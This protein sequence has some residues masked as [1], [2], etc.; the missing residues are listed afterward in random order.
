MRVPRMV[1]GPQSL[2]AIRFSLFYWSPGVRQRWCVAHPCLVWENPP[3]WWALNDQL[4]IAGAGQRV[5]LT[6]DSILR[7]ASV[8][9]LTR[10]S[11]SP[12]AVMCANGY[13]HF[14]NSTDMD[15]LRPTSSPRLRCRCAHHAYCLTSSGV[16]PAG[17]S[18]AARLH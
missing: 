14:S 13:I 17:S 10:T 18:D 8:A 11:I 4:V 1:C 2:A 7:F 6:L 15:Q 5:H 16:G 9:L 3:W 12:R